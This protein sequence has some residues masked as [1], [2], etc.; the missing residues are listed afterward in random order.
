[1]KIKQTKKIRINPTQE[2]IDR[3]IKLGEKAYAKSKRYW[4]K[5]QAYLDSTFNKTN[6][7]VLKDLKSE[8]MRIS[9]E[10]KF[11]IQN[12][13]SKFGVITD[14]NFQWSELHNLEDM[15]RAIE[16]LLD[17]LY[18]IEK[19]KLA[20]AM[21]DLYISTLQDMDKLTKEYFKDLDKL[22]P[23]QLELGMIQD[24]NRVA[25]MSGLE[26]L[27]RR[28]IGTAFLS[29]DIW[30]F[31]GIL[32]K[33]LDWYKGFSGDKF[34]N[35]IDRRRAIVKHEINQAIKNTYIKGMGVDS[36]VKHIT[37]RLNVSYSNA[38]RLAH[39]ELTYAQHCA[40]S[41]QMKQ[42]GFKGVKRKTVKDSHVCPICKEHEGEIVPIEEYEKNP[43]VMMLHVNCRDYG[44]P[45]MSLDG[46]NPFRKFAE[47]YDKEQSK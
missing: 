30:D 5:R 44:V 17:E 27:I 21:D 37:D 11:E 9:K 14:P 22:V 6:N 45:V 16:L 34:Y 13:Y 38:K 2:Q 12:W 28:E 24:V 18:D 20:E 41:K 8:Y 46:E 19:N 29:D 33:P 43:N 47:K 36:A 40:D 4:N 23:D 32:R 31:E 3:E 42:N 39:N 1:M 25:S 26:S 15:Q 7:Q 35:R 10:I